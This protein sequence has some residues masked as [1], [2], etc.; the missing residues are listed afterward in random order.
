MERVL[1]SVST[2][3][4]EKSLC[5]FDYELL[6]QERLATLRAQQK[7]ATMGL[8]AEEALD[9]TVRNLSKA[10]ASTSYRAWTP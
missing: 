1:S 7:E 10:R 8:T 3:I 6:M 4:L 5:V 9:D 2:L